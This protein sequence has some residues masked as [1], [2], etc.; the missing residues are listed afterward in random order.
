MSPD[1]GAFAACVRL[2]LPLAPAPAVAAPD[3][4]GAVAALD[5]PNDA[6]LPAFAAGGAHVGSD[7]ATHDMGAAL[8]A[9]AQSPAQLPSPGSN[10][11]FAASAGAGSRDNVVPS[12]AAAAASEAAA[13]DSNGIMA[14][15]MDALTIGA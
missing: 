9:A 11:N 14:G 5:L 12:S 3:A 2:L 13:N 8:A 1:V 4:A 6:S 15:A 7:P 10:G